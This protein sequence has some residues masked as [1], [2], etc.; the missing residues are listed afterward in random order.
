ML[1]QD[2]S[3]TPDFMEG[4]IERRRLGADHIR[5]A[6]IAL[7]GRVELVAKRVGAI[8]VGARPWGRPG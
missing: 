1:G 5:F 2:T 3:E 8:P 4:I 7:H 6:E